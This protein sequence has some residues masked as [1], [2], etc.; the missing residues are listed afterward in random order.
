MTDSDTHGRT[1]APDARHAAA[2]LLAELR[3]AGA[4]LWDAPGLAVVDRLLAQAQHAPLAL[5]NHLNE[6]AH[7]H[8][9]QLQ[10]DFS[11][12]RER[13]AHALSRLQAA[14]HPAQ[15]LAAEALAR[16]D[17]LLPRRWLRRAPQSSPR[18][19]DEL[20]RSLTEQ[21]D[22]QAEARGISSPGL[23]ESPL[24]QRSSS[25][26]PLA[27]AQSLY[28]DTA[29]GAAASMTLAKTSASV[30]KGAG[31]YHPVH[32][33]ARTFEEAA[34]HP[35]YLKAVL[36][37]LETLGVMWHH[38]LIAPS[39]KPKKAEAKKPGPKRSTRGGTDT[40]R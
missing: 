16:G 38:S 1:L 37:R 24:A 7:A 19:R 18:L 34:R 27:V 17:T 23:I 21:L 4:E 2:A 35:A 5:A 22:A 3:A 14:E 28:H 25:M 26:R 32:I 20:R 33:A 29:A 39:Q 9:G 8:L 10:H 40:A 31:R 15:P 30:P 36:C 11:L 12:A 6:R 13:G